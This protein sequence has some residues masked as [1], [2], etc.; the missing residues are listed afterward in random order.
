[1]PHC[2]QHECAV[3]LVERIVRVN[4]E[5]PPVLIL[6]ILLPQKPYFMYPPFNNCL[7]TTAELLRTSV[8]LGLLPR[9]HKHTLIQHPPPSLPHAYWPYPMALVES[10]EAP[11]HQC[12]VGRLGWATVVHPVSK[13]PNNMP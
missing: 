7:Q 1:M 6:S 4:K 2:P 11:R 8:L 5:E 13:L 12:S 9:H 10:D 3:L